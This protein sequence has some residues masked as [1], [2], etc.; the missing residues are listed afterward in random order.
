[1]ARLSDNIEELDDRSLVR[2]RLSA[3]SLVLRVREELE[4]RSA[5][6]PF[7]KTSKQSVE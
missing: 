6:D 1:M 7:Q 4:L 2:L 3:T 5:L